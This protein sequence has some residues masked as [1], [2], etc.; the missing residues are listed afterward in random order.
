[1]LKIATAVSVAHQPYRL[2]VVTAFALLFTLHMVDPGQA[3]EGGVLPLATAD[4]QEIEKVLGPGIILQA[5]PGR[6]LLPAARYLPKTSG[7][8]TY[9]LI[10]KGK[11]SGSETHLIGPADPQKDGGDLQYEIKSVS[12]SIFAASGQDDRTIVREYDFDQKVVSSFTPGQP[13]IVAGLAPGEG[14]QTHIDVE[15]ADIAHPDKVDYRG[16]LDVTYTNLGR[17]HIR[18]PAGEYDADLVKWT[19][20]GDIGPASVKT[21]QYRF[22]AENA[23][24]VA[25]VQWRS[26]SAMLIYHERSLIGKLLAKQP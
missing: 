26:I 1:M 20:S 6:A 18:V 25:M 2:L 14:R 23:G 9:D 5:L 17:F 15:V 8:I 12:R 16:A 3:D 22:I 19:F 24:M 21:A 7:T 13:L 11:K 10:T 4:R